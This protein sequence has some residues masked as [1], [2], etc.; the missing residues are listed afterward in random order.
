MSIQ[1]KTKIHWQMLPNKGTFWVQGM[2]KRTPPYGAAQGRLLNH[3]KPAGS[4]L[5]DE[6]A[7]WCKDNDC[8]K[9]MSFNQFKFRTEE[10][11]TMFML[12]WS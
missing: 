4:E 11:L 3:Y 6:I 8:G 10:E 7:E 9:R 12:R 2:V 5:I 1:D